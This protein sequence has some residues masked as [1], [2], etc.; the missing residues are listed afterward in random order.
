[1]ATGCAFG[2]GFYF[3]LKFNDMT[4]I[5][6]FL[7]LGIGVDDMFVIGKRWDIFFEES[8]EARQFLFNFLRHF[9]HGP[10]SFYLSF[11]YLFFL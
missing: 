2:L 5:I 11:L 8:S 6:P 10:A 7:L 4:P 9:C 1:M 3:Q